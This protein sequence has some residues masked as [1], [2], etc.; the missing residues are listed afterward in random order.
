MDEDQTGVFVDDVDDAVLVTE[1]CGVVAGQFADEG[2]A[3]V[4]I[5]CDAV[6]QDDH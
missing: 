1:S 4:W 6:S 2:F 5:L 3:L